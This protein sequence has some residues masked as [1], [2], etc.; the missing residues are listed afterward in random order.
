[1]NIDL[2]HE[3]EIGEDSNKS[4]EECTVLQLERLGAPC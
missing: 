1:M 4:L 3:V 2:S